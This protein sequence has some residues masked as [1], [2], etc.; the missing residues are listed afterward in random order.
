MGSL[1]VSSGEDILFCSFLVVEL[2]LDGPNGKLEKQDVIEK[3][4]T[5]MRIKAIKVNNILFF[6]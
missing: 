4:K 5:M 2:E 1:L 6:I 3:A